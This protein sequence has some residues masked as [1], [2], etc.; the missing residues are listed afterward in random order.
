MATPDRPQTLQ[1][2]RPAP[3]TLG[4][5]VLLLLVA[6]LAG[7]GVLRALVATGAVP[8]PAF[9]SLNAEL[10]LKLVRLDELYRTNGRIDCIILG[11]SQTDQALDPEVFARAIAEGG[12][13]AI[14]CYNFS[15]GTLTA[16]P[17]GTLAHLLAVRYHP[18][19]LIYGTSARDYSS[20]FGELTRPL[21]QDAW[22]QYQ[23]GQ[24]SLEGWL[25]EHSLLYR[26]MLT[27]RTALNP[28]YQKFAARLTAQ[29]TPYG[30]LV[31]QR[32]SLEDDDTNFIPE[33]RP[34]PED[35][36]GL[37]KLLALRSSGVQ[38]LVFEVP[39]HPDFLNAYV[40]AD[41]QAYFDAFLRPIQRRVQKQGAPFWATYELPGSILPDDGWSDMKHLNQRGGGIFSRWMANRTL[42]AIRSGEMADPFQ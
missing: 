35:L 26:Q 21:N 36:A 30:Y 7:E 11:S 42:D 2:T 6:W 40:E 28:D 23:L 41:R 16:S 5:G 32:T 18:T 10:D 27:W 17:A 4:L 37:D 14:T 3:Y 20:K 38:V 12:G 1:L 25:A 8:L 9:R 19:L 39:V 24:P 31:S 33:Y 34:L 15:L 29:L 22:V 13:P